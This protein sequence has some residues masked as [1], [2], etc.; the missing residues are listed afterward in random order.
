M[1][2]CCAAVVLLASGLLRPIHSPWV[3]LPARETRATSWTSGKLDS[4]MLG[5]IAS[6]SL[7]STSI[8][9]CA[10]VTRLAAS[11]MGGPELARAKMNT[12]SSGLTLSLS[13]GA[14]STRTF[15]RAPAAATAGAEATLPSPALSFSCARSIPPCNAAREASPSGNC[16]NRRFQ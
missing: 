14:S 15:K 11:G 7:S 5:I 10:T 4:F 1:V 9:N 2:R 16:T 12:V 3:G 13:A 6:L 8:G